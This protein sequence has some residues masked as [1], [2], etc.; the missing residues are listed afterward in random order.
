MMAGLS[1]TVLRLGALLVT[2]PLTGCV[3]AAVVGVVTLCRAGAEDWPQTKPLAQSELVT[4]IEGKPVTMLSSAV[5]PRD[6]GTCKLAGEFYY[7]GQLLNAAG[8]GA[9]DIPQSAAEKLRDRLLASPDATSCTEARIRVAV[10]SQD[11]ARLE[12][13]WIKSR[14]GSFRAYQSQTCSI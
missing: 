9:Q 1:H 11:T 6:D 7:K 14:D 10:Q 8:P 12:L 5:A 3:A 13:S 4:E 2:V